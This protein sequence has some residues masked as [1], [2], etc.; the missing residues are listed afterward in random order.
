M[1]VAI[2]VLSVVLGL[3]LF[4]NYH[5]IK[6]MLRIQ[7]NCQQSLDYIDQRYSNLERWMEET[8]LVTN[9]P[10][11]QKFV[12][13]I[14]LAMNGIAFATNVLKEPSDDIE[15]VI[16]EMEKK[17]REESTGEESEDGKK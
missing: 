2:I 16:E 11:A 3:S 5:L 15:K 17:E 7:D 9:D 12:N 13:E 10:I 6:M 1:I 4:G 8:Y 14:K